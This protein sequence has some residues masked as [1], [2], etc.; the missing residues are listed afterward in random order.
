MGNLILE[1]MHETDISIRRQALNLLYALCRPATWQEIVDELL[2]ILSSSDSLLQEELVL[3]IA[4]LAEK[5]APDFKWYV[6]VIFRMLESAPDSVPDDVWYRV[7]QVVTGFEDGLSES[8]KSNLQ[9]HAA[10]K[11]YQ[12][13]TGHG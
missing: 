6:D 11:A 1:K 4:I 12:N 3:K 13:L 10:S 8:E 7:V 9:R 2:E 5:N